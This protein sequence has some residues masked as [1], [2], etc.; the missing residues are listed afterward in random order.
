ID[1]GLPQI[2]AATQ[3][4]FVPQMLNL[5]WLMAIDFDKGCYPGQEVIARLHYRGRL[6][7]RTFRIGWQGHCPAPGEPVYDERDD[8]VGQILQ[9]AGDTEGR[10][11]AVL[12][13]DTAASGALRTENAHAITLLDLP[14][15]TDE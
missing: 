10:A 8:N 4:E 5:H 11:L 6:T 2:T 9:A 13:V 1:A 3:S 12:R 15:P 14:Y 7:R